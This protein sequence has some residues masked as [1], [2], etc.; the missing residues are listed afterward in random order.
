MVVVFLA[1]L[2]RYLCAVLGC[3]VVFGLVNVN[4]SDW[5]RRLVFAP[6]KRSA[7]KIVS[8]MTYDAAS[9]RVGR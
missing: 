4:E 9:T 5:S 7:V 3:I 6:V 2:L 1:C 8:E